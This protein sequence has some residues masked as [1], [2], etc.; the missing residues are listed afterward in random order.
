MIVV[1]ENQLVGMLAQADVAHAG[2]EKA[3]GEMVDAISRAPG[4][5]R[6]AGSD[7]DRGSEARR[8]ESAAGE[9]QA[10]SHPGS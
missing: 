7:A 9:E 5:P 3:T 4:G 1:H 10:Q 8:P 6:V 2:K